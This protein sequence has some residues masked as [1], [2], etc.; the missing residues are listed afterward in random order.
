MYQPRPRPRGSARRRHALVEGVDNND[1]RI[2]V[3]LLISGV[4]VTETVFAIPGLG[5]L[6]WT[7]FCAATAR[8]SR[9]ADSDDVAR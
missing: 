1:Y 6:Q 7:R 3:A 4:V 2:G 8:S 5:R 9:G